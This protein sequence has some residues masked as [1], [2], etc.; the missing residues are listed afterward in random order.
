[1]YYRCPN[2]TFFQWCDEY[3]EGMNY[4]VNFKHCNVQQRNQSQEH[5]MFKPEPMVIQQQII[6]VIWRMQQFLFFLCVMNA[7][8]FVLLFSEVF[9]MTR[10]LVSQLY[11]TVIVVDIRLINGLNCNFYFVSI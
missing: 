11:E 5:L 9:Y 1:M 2:C 4:N 10:E 6:D 8:V 3:V 7:F